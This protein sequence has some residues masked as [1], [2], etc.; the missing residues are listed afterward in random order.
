MI[1]EDYFRIHGDYELKDGLYNVDGHVELIEFVDKLP[2]KFGN[3]SG[4]FECSYNY[5]TSLE[6]CPKSVGGDFL[7]SRNKLTS[8]EGAP[9]QVGGD[10]LCDDN[11][12]NT[13]E[14]RQHK[15][16]EKEYRQY[17]IMKKLR[18]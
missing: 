10:F 8:L 6:G 5:L 14:Y 12:R 18:K 17:L 13:K 1:I 15:I 2:F 7:C 11:L 16:M 4:G 9:K 3:V